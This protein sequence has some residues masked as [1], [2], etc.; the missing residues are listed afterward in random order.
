M[1]IKEGLDVSDRRVL[2]SGGFADVRRGRYRWHH[3]AVKTVRVTEGGDIL[4]IRKVR[5]KVIFPG[6][7]DMVS[8]TPLQQFCK[9]V[10][11]WNTLSHPNI[12]KLDGVQGDMGAGLFT[13]VS[14]W[15]EHGNIM[16]YIK[17]NNVNRL[18]L[19]RDFTFPAA[20]FA[21]MR[22]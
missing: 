11:L 16:E 18:E 1:V 3:V 21:E 22:Q 12:L 15:M 17:R 8:T 9:E 10:V 19:V 4:K 13:T 2:A 14:E 20:F 5:T 6:T 7:Y